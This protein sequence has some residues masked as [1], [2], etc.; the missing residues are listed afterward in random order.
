M[1]YTRGWNLI[2]MGQVADIVSATVGTGT[3]EE[4]TITP[5]IDE[6]WILKQ[7]G[8]YVATPA[9]SASGTHEIRLTYLT[10]SPSSYI[11][12][13]IRADHAQ[14]ITTYK[15][16][17]PYST[18]TVEIPDTHQGILEL[19]AGDMLVATSDNPLIFRYEND[20]DVDQTN[21]RTY[22]YRYMRYRKV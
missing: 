18:T 15:N 7:L 3:V 19:I 9:G 13:L 4:K 16:G 11:L 20:T 10:G 2:D 8:F 12:Y 1:S 6:I 14:P 17:L 5:A 22:Y 21:A